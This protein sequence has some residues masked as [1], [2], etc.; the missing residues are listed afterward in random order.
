[1]KSNVNK[2]HM[3]ARRLLVAASACLVFAACS[4]ESTKDESERNEEGEIEEGGDVGVFALK[5]GD[6]FGDASTVGSVSDVAATPCSE[7]HVNEVYHQFDL[8]E[9][10]ADPNTAATN[11]EVEETC[12]AEFEKYVGVAYE[13]STTYEIT[14]LYPDPTAWETGERGVDCIVTSASGEPTTGSAKGT[15]A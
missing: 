5:V 2:I 7:P 4:T 15:G 11:P 10:A 12:L 6:C 14:F 3:N 8:P 1:M 9:G 13:S